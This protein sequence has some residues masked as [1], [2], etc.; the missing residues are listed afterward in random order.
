MVQDNC[1]TSFKIWIRIAKLHQF[2]HNGTSS[3][4]CLAPAK[5]S[6]TIYCVANPPIMT[7]H[8]TYVFV[9]P[10]YC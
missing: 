4:N 1:A 8:F 3:K 9:V 10:N 5:G 6:L 7:R 2:N